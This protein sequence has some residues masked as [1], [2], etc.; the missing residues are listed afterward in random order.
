MFGV[1][2]YGAFV[3]AIIVFLM[4]PGPGNFALMIST[5]KGGIKGG[6]AA[7]CGVIIGDQV[8]MWLAVAGVAA[9][10]HAFPSVFAV[11]QWLGAVYL[12][13]LGIR[14]LR[15]KPEREAVFVMQSHHYLRQACVITLL[16]PKAIMFYMAFFP[17]FIDQG[18]HR[19][20]V[21]F[22]AMALTVAVLA[23][24]YGAIVIMVTHFFLWRLRAKPGISRLF[25]KLA[26]LF[27]IGFGVRLAMGR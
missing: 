27:L 11:V 1:T 16:N 21:T 2:D 9:M 17:L 14:M 3:V 26:G 22:V 15:A 13:W 12:V 18:Q 20:S 19:G 10:L 7:V 5:G 4:I 8:L 6:L 24:L 23:F 25:E